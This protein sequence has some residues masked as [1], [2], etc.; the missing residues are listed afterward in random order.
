MEINQQT[1]KLIQSLKDYTN[2][3]GGEAVHKIKTALENLGNCIDALEISVDN[4]WENMKQASRERA[5]VNL[6]TLRMQRIQMAQWYGSLK[7]GFVETWEHTKKGFS[8][9]YLKLH[10]TW[11]KYEQGFSFD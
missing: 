7:S 10:K 1:Q 6:K 2:V 9:A 8:S 4:N 5:R 11:E 3:Q